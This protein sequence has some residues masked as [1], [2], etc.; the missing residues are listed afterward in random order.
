VDIPQA[1]SP[2]AHVGTGAATGTMLDLDVSAEF[3]RSGVT[4]SGMI[5]RCACAEDNMIL[6]YK[7]A[8][9]GMMVR[10]AYAAGGMMVRGAYAAAGVSAGGTFVVGG[11]AMGSE[12]VVGLGKA[13]GIVVLAFIALRTGLAAVNVVQTAYNAVQ[14]NT[15][16]IMAANP[17]GPVVTA[18]A[19][20][21][22]GFVL[23]YNKLNIYR[24]SLLLSSRR[25]WSPGSCRSRGGPGGGPAQVRGGARPDWA[26]RPMLRRHD[27]QRQAPVGQSSFWRSPLRGRRAFAT[28]TAL[29]QQARRKVVPSA[30]AL[31]L[32]NW[33]PLPFTK[34]SLTRSAKVC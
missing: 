22:A 26:T 21:A 10:G 3:L 18:I 29:V 15:N 14:A 30:N 34:S 8:A 11:M 1:G 5:L 6:L 23:A 19:T 9:G 25:R 24:R 4:M 16:A 27:P 28:R 20:L 31:A 12:V 33:K 17:V 32:A 2:Q 7:V 13:L